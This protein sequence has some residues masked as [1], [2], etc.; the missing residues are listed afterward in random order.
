MFN[1]EDIYKMMRNGKSAEDIA[2]AF[3]DNLNKAQAQMKADEEEKAKAAKKELAL[4]EQATIMA[5]AFNNYMSLRF[6]D[7]TDIELTPD[8]VMKTLDETFETTA[9]IR[10]I[11]DSVVKNKDTL[12]SMIEDF[13]NPKGE[14]KKVYTAR[15]HS[16]DD[17]EDIIFRFLDSL[18]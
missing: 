17:D 12:V 9:K 18:R 1:Y 7:D 8:E 6:G 15:I 10:S 16:D 14:K 5:D 2:K 3:S 11:T 13:F 4:R